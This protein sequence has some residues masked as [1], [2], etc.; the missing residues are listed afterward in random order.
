M[1]SLTAKAP[2]GG[3]KKAKKWRPC[4]RTSLLSNQTSAFVNPYYSFMDEDED[5]SKEEEG[6]NRRAVAKEVRETGAGSEDLSHS[7]LSVFSAPT[8]TL[9]KSTI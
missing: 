4:W 1:L 7:V 2:S 5:D 3:P 6:A 8:R 9:A